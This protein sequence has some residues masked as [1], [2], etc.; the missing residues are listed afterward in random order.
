MLVEHPVRG[1]AGVHVG[2]RERG[3]VLERGRVHLAVAGPFEHRPD[4]VGHR[5]QLAHLVRQEVARSAGNAINH[6]GDDRV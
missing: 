5:A 4:P 3:L 2:A 6:A 1:S